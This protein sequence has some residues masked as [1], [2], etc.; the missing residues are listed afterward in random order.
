MESSSFQ[1]TGSR[2]IRPNNIN[3]NTRLGSTGD[4]L[5]YSSPQRISDLLSS[6]VNSSPCSFISATSTGE[7]DNNNNIEL[8][9][10]SFTASSA[11]RIRTSSS[12]NSYFSN[13]NNTVPERM[14]EGRREI[15]GAVS[16]S[17]RSSNNNN[18][19]NNCNWK[20][21]HN[22]H[23]QGQEH[24][25]YATQGHGQEQGQGQHQCPQGDKASFE[26]RFHDLNRPRPDHIQ[27]EQHIIVTAV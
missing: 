10:C 6:S 4:D 23:K 1:E 12:S 18:N 7:N 24:L 5:F 22:R 15:E 19:N 20:Y 14:S 9:S 16:G 13:F 27:Q 25:L 8:V 17:V 2:P 3:I 11:S 26:D 21:S